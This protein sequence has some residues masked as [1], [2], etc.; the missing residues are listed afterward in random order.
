LKSSNLITLKRNLEKHYKETLNLKFRTD[1]IDINKISKIGDRDNLF[2]FIELVVGCILSY[3]HKE[4]YISKILNLDIRVQSELMEF[5][6]KIIRKLNSNTEIE[7]TIHEVKQENRKLRLQLEDFHNTLQEISGINEELSNEKK[8]LLAQKKQLEDTIERYS[9]NRVPTEINL[10]FIET[11]INSKDS[12]IDELKAKFQALQHKYEKDTYQ[13]QEELDFAN[14]KILD[15]TKTKSDLELF[16][17]KL[18]DLNLYKKKSLD[19]QTLNQRL[20]DDLK[21]AQKENSVNSSTQAQLKSYKDQLEELKKENST[22][23]N[24][25][26]EKEKCYKDLLKHKKEIED[27]KIFFENQSKDLTAE[28]AGLKRIRD[29]DDEN[30]SLT[31]VF[32]QDFEDQAHKLRSA[33]QKIASQNEIIEEI[34]RELNKVHIEKFQALNKLIHE[35]EMKNGLEH[36]IH[37]AKL[38]KKQIF[39]KNEEKVA[40]LTKK[41]NDLN[42]SNLKSQGKIQKLKKK[43]EVFKNCFEENKRLNDLKQTYEKEIKAIY[44]DKSKIYTKIDLQQEENQ[45]IKTELILKTNHIEKLENELVKTKEDLSKERSYR[46]Q[47]QADLKSYEDNLPI[48]QVRIQELNSQTQISELKIKLK[49]KEETLQKLL[50]EK[51][52]HEFAVAESI[53]LKISKVSAKHAEEKKS[54]EEMLQQRSLEVEDLKKYNFDLTCNWNREIKFLSMVINEAGMECFKASRLLKKEEKLK[55]YDLY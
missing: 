1:F 45:K 40:E 37:A 55:V 38:K 27:A 20:S 31:K 47:L 17:K 33:N 46:I 22:L 52:A 23:N 50:N 36:K 8:D 25:L 7:E 13:L 26:V 4:R 54:L 34:N 32:N 49:E 18:E 30:F 42:E 43:L 11:Q 21:N 39:K 5:I 10:N 51:Q 48:E 3:E 53:N 16:K 19:L 6:T 9:H 24:N 35:K 41:I 28:I 2:I 12:T 29:K 14:E 44:E 15:Y